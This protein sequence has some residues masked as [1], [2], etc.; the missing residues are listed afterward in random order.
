ME[1]TH[2]ELTRL[3]ATADGWPA[4]LVE[5]LATEAAAPDRTH[6]LEIEGLGWKPWGHE[7]FSLCHFGRR[8]IRPGKGGGFIM[9]G[10]LWKRDPTAAHLDLPDRRVIARPEHWRFPVTPAMRQREPLYALLNVKGINLAAD[11]F[12]YPAASA[13]AEWFQWCIGRV[14]G[15]WGRD[16]ALEALAHF[17]GWTAHMAQDEC[18]PFHSAGLMFGG[19][20]EFE[21]AQDEFFS[22]NR[23]DIEKMLQNVSPQ[24]RIRTFR[25]LVEDCAGFSYVGPNLLADM[26][27]QPTQRIALVAKSVL[28]AAVATRNL[29]RLARTTYVEK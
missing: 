22:R 28:S 5:V 25:H 12:S 9:L 1:R 24:S 23:Q 3:V 27:Q 11:E 17:V 29:L 14:P 2:V 19:H 16:T 8:I 15:D 10:Y 6:G 13:Y 18:Q 4:E 21:G 20:A 7:A 26:M